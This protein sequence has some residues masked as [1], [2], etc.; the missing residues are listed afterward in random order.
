M[1]FLQYVQTNALTIVV[2]SISYRTNFFRNRDPIMMSSIPNKAK[3]NAKFYA[4]LANN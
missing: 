3:P 2:F 4:Q 1:L